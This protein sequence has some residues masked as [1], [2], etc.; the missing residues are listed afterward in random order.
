MKSFQTTL[1]IVLVLAVTLVCGALY[2]RLSHRWGPSAD[3]QAAAEKLE[4]IPGHFG[5]WKQESSEKMTDS[6][7]EMLQCAG[8][9]SRVYVNQV[10][11]ERV[12]VAVLLGPPGPIAVHTPE[13]CYSTKD[14]RQQETRKP[15]AIG[16]EEGKEDAFWFLTFRSNNLRGNLLRVC[17]GWSTGERWSAFKEPR[18]LFA[19]RP[20]LYKIQLAA[21]LPPW[22]NLETRDPCR[23]FLED[24]VPAAKEYLVEP[25]V[26]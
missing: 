19:G 21:P 5:N 23:R 12:N 7:V 26:N 10:T 20:Y 8:Y 14:Y 3:M 13:V 22:V 25:S 24:F 18:Y 2:G 6:V 11:G 9:I 16:K 15:L 4:G 17:Y 1:S